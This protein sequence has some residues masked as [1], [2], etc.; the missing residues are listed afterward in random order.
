[1]EYSTSRIRLPELSEAPSRRISLSSQYKRHGPIVTPT[2]KPRAASIKKRA[3]LPKKVHAA[4]NIAAHSQPPLSLPLSL[5]DVCLTPLPVALPDLG[6]SEST[7]RVEFHPLNRAQEFEWSFEMIDEPDPSAAQ[8]YS[9]WEPLTQI[10]ESHEVRQTNSL[11]YKSDDYL[12]FFESVISGSLPFYQLSRKTFV[13]NGWNTQKSEASVSGSVDLPFQTSLKVS[14]ELLVPYT[15]YYRR[16]Q[17]D[18]RVSLS[19]IQ[20][21]VLVRPFKVHT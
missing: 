2:R 9:E 20:E 14:L 8:S 12:L 5:P 13:S 15:R 21:D 10:A 1:M 7:T 16:N 19:R 6:N 11:G 3:H 4:R 18:S 17:K